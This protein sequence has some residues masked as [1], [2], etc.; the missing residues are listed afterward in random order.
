[1]LLLVSFGPG[2]GNF[3]TKSRI[4]KN[5]EAEGH[6]PWR[7]KVKKVITTRGVPTNL[8]RGEAQF[9]AK[10]AG[11]DIVKNKRKKRSS[12]PHMSNFPRK[13]K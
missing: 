2:V 11:P 7:S 5:F 1:M 9:K 6:T 10:P 12:R 13:D 3:C 4:G 8:K